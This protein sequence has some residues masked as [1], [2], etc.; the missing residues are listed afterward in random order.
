MDATRYSAPA[1]DSSRERRARVTLRAL[2][3]LAVATLLSATPALAETADEQEASVAV[4]SNIASATATPVRGVVTV[5]DREDIVLSGMRTVSDLLLSR[6]TYNSFGLHRPFVLGTG[7][8]AVLI[9]GRRISDSTL[10]LATLPTSA[11]ERVEILGSAASALHGGHAIAGAVNIVLRR[12]YEGVELLA[13]AN[14]PSDAGGD[15]DQG[16]ALWGGAVG[17]GH[18]TIG[19]DVFQREEIPDAAREHSRAKWTPGGLFADASGVSIGGNTV[20]I[21]TKSYDQ[22]GDVTATHVPGVEVQSIARPLGDCADSIFTGELGKPRDVEGTGCGFPYANVSWNR[23]RYER[24]SLFLALDHPLDDIT[25]AYLDVRLATD[26]TLERYAPSVGTFAVPSATLESHLPPDPRIDSLPEEVLVAHRFIGHGNREWHTTL[27][28]HD[29]TF[30][31]EGQLADGIGYDAHLRHYRH[32]SVVD[33]NTFVSETSAR[34][35]IQEGR[36]DLANPLS[37]TNRETIREISLRLTQDRVTEHRTARASLH[38]PMFAL[39][40][41]EA[42]WAV[43]TEVAAEHWKDV[44]AYRDRSG[45]SYDAT[46]VL[47]AGGTQA[48]GKRRRWSGFAEA[49]LP[50]RENW[51]VTLAGRYDGYDDVGTA[52]SH[53]VASS[54][55]V[56]EA[57][58]LRGFWD[59]GSRPP[60][61]YEL[62]LRSANDFPW[63]CDRTTHT[64]PLSACPVEQVVRVGSGNP[65]LEPDDAE[66][67]SVGAVAGVEPLSLSVDWFQIALS[68][69]PAQLSPQSIMDLE[70]EG[71][72]PSGVAVVRDSRGLID[73]IESPWVNSRESDV[74][75]ID[76]RARVGWDAALAVMVFDAR[77][78]HV[79]RDETQ[80]AGERQPGD[81]PRKRVHGSL[82][83]SWGDVTAS[84]S[85]HAVSSVWNAR[86]TGRFDGWVG[87]DISVR[88]S[89]AL[90]LGGLD[91]IGGILNVGNRGPS[92]DPTDPD[93]VFATLDSVRGRTFFVNASMAW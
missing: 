30:G 39:D 56:H 45:Q 71:A 49:L 10:D 74:S 43:G 12:G 73:Q 31:V 11:V 44:H 72:L 83:A 24:E 3:A 87:H 75:G 79:S 19:V 76:V 52:L 78:L 20:F 34:R 69:V 77:W 48:E 57:V 18:M 29:L 67:F 86:R 59:R 55:R 37:P 53:Q 17:Q 40:G 88:W 22:N 26:E 92:I 27:D 60:S 21:A 15:A 33:G 68:N 1:H 2:A 85:V 51:D 5:I 47:G 25:D 65:D 84:W 91:L 46:D 4:A 32:N 61:L 62:H 42:R 58:T 93:A 66:S 8:A 54:I 7:R 14:R 6:L 36:Y 81:F 82:R 80:V 38:G 35:A 13:F 50:V 23:A 70:A 89:N 28:E 41:G 63:V 64:G 9:N 16:S 90:G